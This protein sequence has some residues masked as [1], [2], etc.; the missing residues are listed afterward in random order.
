MKRAHLVG[1]HGLQCRAGA[2]CGR[3]VA[4]GGPEDHAAEGE[5]RHRRG[6]VPGLIERGQPLLP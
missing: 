3:T 6:V 4:V 1:G 2:A 5:G